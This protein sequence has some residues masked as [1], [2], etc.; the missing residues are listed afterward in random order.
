MEEDEFRKGRLKND[1]REKNG[2]YEVKK[3]GRKEER[4][5]GA[6][7]KKRE[8]RKKEGRREWREVVL[9]QIEIYRKGGRSVII[10]ERCAHTHTHIYIYTYIH[11]KHTHRMYD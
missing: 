8:G 9:V 11:I 4:K 2:E 10:V 3:E 1:I 6:R 5:K 7:G